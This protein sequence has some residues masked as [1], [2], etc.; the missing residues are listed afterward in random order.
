MTPNK[1]IQEFEHIAEA[2]NGIQR[3]RELV[4]E[5]AVR[6]LLIPQNP[7]DEPASFLLQDIARQKDR[8]INQ[9]RNSKKEEESKKEVEG[10][11]YALPNGWRWSK[12]RDV[13]YEF[14]QKVPDESFTYIDVTAINKERGFIEED[15]Q[16]L[17]P[18]EAPSRARKVVDVGTVIYS[19]VR[20]YLLN[21]AIVDRKLDPPPIVSTAFFVVHPFAGISNRYLFYYLRSKPFIDYVNNAMTGMA[22]PAVNDAKMAAGPVPIPPRAEQQRIVA[23]V[24][25]L[26]KR[27][28]DLE[29]WQKQR[30]EQH[31][32][33]TASCLHALASTPRKSG[34]TSLSRVSDNFNLL[35][36]TPESIAELRKTI[37]QLAVQGRLVPQ[38]PKEE[39][40]S[41]LLESIRAKKSSIVNDLHTRI[42]EAEVLINKKDRAF[43]L[44]TGW[45]WVK[46]AELCEKL[47]AGSTPLGG[48]QVYQNSGVPFIRSQNVWNQGL[49]LDDV[50][51]IPR[52]IHEQMSGTWVLPG[53]IL[54]NITGASIGRSAIVHF[55]FH[56]GNV[57]QHVAI[58]RLVEKELHRFLHLV[59]ISEDFQR[60]IMDVQVGVS[61]EG[62]SMTRLKEFVVALPP[63]NEQRRI[64]ACVDALL[65]ICDEVETKLLRAQSD[66]D[67]LVHSFVYHLCKRR[68]GGT[69]EVIL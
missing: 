51:L 56:E 29:A 57:S 2:P 31:T 36:D 67:V 52:E 30:N 5:L 25:E 44:P 50:A 9:S 6:G 11:P 38:D 3:L 7:N 69:K 61:R 19:T 47:G 41:M 33:L 63:L 14:G 58:I 43:E 21:I 23:K 37:L 66:A 68:S 26:M 18:E 65:K 40:A 20:P 8:L 59:I 39:P 42:P 10:N 15:L 60:R 32:M 34:D 12:L 54:L 13:S 28:D 27:C 24:D 4:L 49:R 17:R 16:V 22:Y 46:L 48:K 1:F 45:E 64:V 35:I 55:E 62:L 53:D